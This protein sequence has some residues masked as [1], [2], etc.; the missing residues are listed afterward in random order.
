M[1]AS[2]KGPGRAVRPQLQPIPVGGPFHY[3]WCRYSP[4]FPSHNGNKY[5][6]VFMDY[7]TKWPEVFATEDQTAE[8]I[9][10]L[11]VEHV[12]ARHGV[13]KQLLSD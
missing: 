6:V 11:L 7:F 9:A 5:A 3:G 13:P 8:T 12:I 4:T 2:R 1:C 10:H